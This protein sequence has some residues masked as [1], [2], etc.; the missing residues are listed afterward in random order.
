[1]N[2]CAIICEYNPFHTGHKY[3]LDTVRNYGAN[4]ILCVMSG[5]FVQSGQPA[6]CDKAIRAECALLGG[7]NAVIELPTVYATA[8]AQYFAEGAVKI[9]SKIKNITHLAMGVVADYDI[10]RHIADIKI[11][12]P[13]K[14]KAALISAM[15]G[16]K[17]Y[18]AAMAVAIIKIYAE[19]YGDGEQARL[20]LSD[21]NNILSMEYIAALQKYAPHI[22]PLFIRRVG[23]TYND[24]SLYGKF[25]SATAVRYAEETGA[26]EST[27]RYIPYKFDDI[28]LYRRRFAPDIDAY[29]KIA[30]FAAKRLS[31]EDFAHLRNCSEG[32][33]YAVAN[34]Q[35]NDFD[36]VIDS[37]IGK[38][39]GKKRIY[40]LMLD[41][42]LDI[43]KS[44][45]DKR[46]ATRLLG[47]VKDFD[48]SI[49]PKQVYTNNADL[50][51][52][53]SVDEEVASVLKT[54]E[55]CALLYNILCG[56]DGG[57][58]NYSLVKV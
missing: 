18:N 39:Y 47:C 31:P 2:N 25:V 35:I 33:E 6:F 57:Y 43:D 54:D 44:M 5:Q 12:N 52:A 17:S 8:N 56:K 10:I 23:G 13:D 15:D 49:L 36:S 55:D 21:P 22:E 34:S 14:V 20:A 29:K 11:E 4:N 16:G 53:A 26:F 42:L 32:L 45:L 37:I 58:Y 50:K 19:K 51:R 27:R 24:S 48:F 7:A 30:L 41:A 3:Q 38:R 9:I 46:F 40:R 1:M 28:E